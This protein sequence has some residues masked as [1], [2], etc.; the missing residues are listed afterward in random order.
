MLSG[1]GGVLG[2]YFGGAWASRYA[3]DN[4]RLQL[5]AIAVAYCVLAVVM[6]STFIVSNLYVAFGC[7]GLATFGASAA[8]GPLFATIQT[9]VPER[10][11]AMSIALIYLF[12]NL[13][14][15]G[16]GPLTA[17]A[18][19]DALRPI[20]GEESLRYA[21]LAL[22]PGYLWAGWYLW[23]ARWTVMTE[24]AHPRTPQQPLTV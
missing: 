17:G 1:L 7:F 19:S 11:R 8:I 16:L 12:A 15:L 13:I 24:L 23:R 14:G 10:M 3:A 4:E 22:C 2:A 21:L 5:A 20:F 6:A 18:L 9:M